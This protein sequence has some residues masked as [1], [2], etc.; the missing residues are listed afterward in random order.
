MTCEKKSVVSQGQAL[1]A[2]R[3]HLAQTIQILLISEILPA[4][5]RGYNLPKNCWYVL[6]SSGALML[7]PSRLLCIDK[8]TGNIVY[9]GPAGDEG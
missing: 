4:N 5:C 8:A 3:E 2:V 6:S 7:G 1:D 9:D